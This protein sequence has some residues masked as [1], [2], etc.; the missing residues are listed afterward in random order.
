MRVKVKVAD[1]DELE[2]EPPSTRKTREFG[3]T[4]KVTVRRVDTD[5][6][7]VARG[8]RSILE[9]RVSV[10]RASEQRISC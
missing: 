4:Q 3:E 2:L 9:F 6:T 7:G 10:R 8:D 1:K 5:S